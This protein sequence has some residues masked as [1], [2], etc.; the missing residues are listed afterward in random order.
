MVNT[1][2]SC[3]FDIPPIKISNRPLFESIMPVVLTM[4]VV[5]FSILYLRKLGKD[6]LKEGMLLGVICFVI[7]LAIDLMMFIPESPMKMSLTDYIMDIGLTYVIIS[8]I[9]IGFGYL[10]EKQRSQNAK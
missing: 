9:C 6:F 2:Y 8:T 4:C 5:L 3:V 7:S 1:V 10:L